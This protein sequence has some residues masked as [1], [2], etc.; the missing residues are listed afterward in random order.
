MSKRVVIIGGGIIGLATARYCRSAGHE[1]TV[2]DRDLPNRDSC[3]FG[4]AGMIVPSHFVPLAAPGMITMGLKWLANPESPF[5]IRPRLSLDLA[6]WLWQ[7]KSASTDE[8]VR[9]SSP[10]LRDLHLASRAEYERLQ[11]ELPSGFDFHPNGLLMLCKTESGLK[12]EIETAAEANRLGVTA[13]VL[14]ADEAARLDPSIAMDIRGAVFFP[15]DCHL[16]PNRLMAV[17]ERRLVDDGVE[18]RWQCEWRGFQNTG[19][20][21]TTVNTS[22]GDLAA[23]EV[24]VCGGVWSPT[25]S[26]ALGIRLPIQAGKGYS[27]TLEQ[28]R[29]LP[30]ICSILTEARVAVT[31]MDGSL[32]FGGTMEIA[33]IDQTVSHSR[34]RG[35]LKSIPQYFPEFQADDFADCE[36]WVGLRPCSPDGLPY[37]GRT[38]AWDNVVISS[39]HAMMGISLAMV[40]GK[41]VAEMVDRKPAS[42]DS[43]ELLSPDRYSG[44]SKVKR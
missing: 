2:I 27:M 30:S 35:I 3:S 9:R 11:S 5:S 29:Q 6:S 38:R 7:F 18:F 31:P 37:L 44:R 25:I 17:L 43:V 13:E 22:T 15:N 20:K 10:L 1:V 28:P 23:D 4:N 41:L 16:S 36:P 33:G 26:K 19:S 21:I 12:E 32:R 14:T 42:I 34:V 24:I 40:S 39:G 8:H